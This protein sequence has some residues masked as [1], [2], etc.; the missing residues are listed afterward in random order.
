MILWLWRLFIRYVI[1]VGLLPAPP[2]PPKCRYAGDCDDDPSPICISGKCRRH[3]DTY[4]G[5]PGCE[6]KLTP[7]EVELLARF[8]GNRLL[9]EHR[10]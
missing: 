7:E 6:K 5:H 9:E 8:R 2:R 4:C 10:S 1:G 3:C